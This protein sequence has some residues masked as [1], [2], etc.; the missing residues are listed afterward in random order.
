M[1]PHS[2]QEVTHL[3]VTLHRYPH[4]LSRRKS[5]TDVYDTGWQEAASQAVGWLVV[6]GEGGHVTGVMPVT[7]PCRRC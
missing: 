7:C 6:V 5:T 1:A 4:S 2:H 3:F